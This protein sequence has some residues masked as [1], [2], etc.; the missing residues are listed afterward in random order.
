MSF[1][2][3]FPC[4]PLPANTRAPPYVIFGIDGSDVTSF[5][6]PRIPLQLVLNFAPIL[7]NWILPAPDPACLPRHIAR[8][9]LRIPYIGI[10]ILAS[11]D[12][13]G[14]NWIITHMLRFSG[15]AL[16]KEAFSALPDLKTSLAIHNA[17]LGLDLPLEGLRNLH[18]HIHAQLM[19]SSPPVSLWDMLMLWS[20]FPHSSEIVRAMGM[21]FIEGHVNLEYKINESMEILAWLQSDPEL[22]AFFKGL[23]DKVPGYV[24]NTLEVVPGSGVRIGE[25]YKTIGKKEGKRIKEAAEKEKAILERGTTRKVSPQERQEREESDFEALKSRLRRVKSDVSLRSVDTAILSTESPEEQSDE[26]TIE[27]QP[28]ND[29]MEDH[30]NYSGGNISDALARS[31]ET[32]RLRREARQMKNKSEHKQSIDLTMANLERHNAADRP[33]VRHRR[34]SSSMTTG[35][36]NEHGL[37]IADL[38]QRIQVLKEKQN[39]LEQ[40]EGRQC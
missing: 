29:D 38:E 31:L 4:R 11:I 5:L 2:L 22:C 13:V 24:E 32:I 14:L 37:S 23:Q 19:L 40:Q 36:G 9:S 35:Q 17:W 30:S 7:Q 21:N 16:P 12:A 8:Q 39:R 10:N 28:V 27:E 20:T 26:G 6:P 1:L 33:H 34:T 3:E 18:T 25:G 15:L